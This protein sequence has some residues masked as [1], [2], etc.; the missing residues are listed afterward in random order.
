MRQ[1]P[2][3]RIAV[4]RSRGRAIARHSTAEGVVA[5]ATTALGQPALLRGRQR[6]RP[7]QRACHP[8]PQPSPQRAAG[9]VGS[10]LLDV[11]RGRR[12]PCLRM[13]SACSCRLHSGPQRDAS[14]AIMHG[15]LA[16]A[17]QIAA[18]IR[19]RRLTDAYPHIRVLLPSLRQARMTV[20]WPS[21]LSGRQ[22]CMC[23]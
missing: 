1:R 11:A 18:R 3:R 20:N 22:A 10:A 17:L 2:R 15:A 12:T 14:D 4:A 16:A 19:R 23:V 9:I 7:P 21:H 13:R 8:G 5:Q 6:M